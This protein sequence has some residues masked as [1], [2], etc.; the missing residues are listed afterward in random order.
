M[1]ATPPPLPAYFKRNTRDL[2]AAELQEYEALAY[3]VEMFGEAARLIA[4]LPRDAEQVLKNTVI[5]SF[6]THFRNLAFFLWRPASQPKDVEAATFAASWTAPTAEPT[7]LINRVSREIAHLTTYRLSGR[8]PEKEWQ[9]MECIKAL[10]PTLETFV[11]QADT[12]KLSP[13][14]PMEVASLRRLV[15]EPAARV[16]FERTNLTTTTTRTLGIH[17]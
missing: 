14:V 6:A 7:D 1:S 17:G 5:E 16:V 10:L 15:D 2:S 3:E 12:A 13:N 9:P 8:R 11:T 4:K